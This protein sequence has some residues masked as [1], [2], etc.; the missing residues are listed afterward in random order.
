MTKHA[1]GLQ[2][3]GGRAERVL[4]GMRD[5]Q[6]GDDHDAQADGAA[7]GVRVRGVQ[8]PARRAERDDSERVDVQGAATQ[9]RPQADERARHGA[10]RVPRQAAPRQGARRV[11]LR[12]ETTA[13]RTREVG[14]V[15]GGWLARVRRHA[16]FARG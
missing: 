13:P 1:G 9:D 4:L 16:G 8:G 11:L 6:P 2:R 12:A 7:E 15:L 10:R 14:A 5:D 3:D